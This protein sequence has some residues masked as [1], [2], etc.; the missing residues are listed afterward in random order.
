MRP[1]MATTT[2]SGASPSR[3]LLLPPPSLDDSHLLLRLRPLLCGSWNQ[4]SSFPPSLPSSSSATDTDIFHVPPPAPAHT[5]STFDTFSH[6]RAAASVPTWMDTLLAS[7]YPPYT[8]KKLKM[9]LFATGVVIK[10]PS[11]GLAAAWSKVWKVLLAVAAIA[12]IRSR[13]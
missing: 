1:A 8:A 6:E 11:T 9:L 7:R 12:A 2:A 13:L 5:G 3:G 4:N 10:R